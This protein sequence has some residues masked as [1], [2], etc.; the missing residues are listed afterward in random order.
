ML[1]LRSV[2]P[3]PCLLLVKLLHGFEAASTHTHTNMHNDTLRNQN[4]N[5]SSL[6]VCQ[7]PRVRF[8]VVLRVRRRRPEVFNPA[9]GPDS[10]LAGQR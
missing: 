6:S 7:S 1:V 4:K 8:S 2:S 10:K 3:V 5:I 9:D